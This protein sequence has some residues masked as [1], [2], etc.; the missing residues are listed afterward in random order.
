MT[1]AG[2]SRRADTSCM[3][4]HTS[5]PNESSIAASI[6]NKIHTCDPACGWDSHK[7]LN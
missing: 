5:V 2:C 4:V 6:V 1:S 3:V 7:S